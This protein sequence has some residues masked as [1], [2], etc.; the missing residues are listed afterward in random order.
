MVIDE[1]WAA[2][3]ARVRGFFAAIPGAVVTED[4]FL[5]EGCRI[6]LTDVPGTLMGKWGI[7]RTRLILEG[8]DEAAA[9][10][11]RRFFL[12]FLSAGG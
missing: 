11:Y 7:R 1:N 6:R 2:D 5:A 8:P 10:L 12:H 4:G 3:P 9:S